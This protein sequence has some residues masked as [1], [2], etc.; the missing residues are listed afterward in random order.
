MSS[1]ITTRAGYNRLQNRLQAELEAYD[2]VCDE[3]AHAA[4]DGDTSVWHDN[5][6]YENNQREMHRLARRIVDTKKII[7]NIKV[8]EAPLSPETAQVGCVVILFDEEENRKWSFEIAG[9]QDGDIEQGRISYNTPLMQKIV[10]GKKGDQYELFLNGKDREVV[11]IAI[12]RIDN[13]EEK[14]NE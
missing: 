3:N 13:K 11:I 10:G 2:K 5:F 4:G 6:A 14:I 8:V 1:Y 9:Y 12:Q 7:E